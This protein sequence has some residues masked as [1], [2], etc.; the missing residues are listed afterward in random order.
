MFEFILFPIE[1]GKEKLNHG[2]V[3]I[4]ADKQMIHFS[5]FWFLKFHISPFIFWLITITIILYNILTK[6]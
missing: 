5:F 1:L 6:L 3:G 4:T 2:L